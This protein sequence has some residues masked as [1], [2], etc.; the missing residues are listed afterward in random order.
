METFIE[1][2]NW[3]DLTA[4]VVVVMV[5]VVGAFTKA[6]IARDRSNAFAWASSLPLSSMA[7]GTK[8]W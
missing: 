6:S 3:A 7:K 1:W 2:D 5:V 4:S 8:T